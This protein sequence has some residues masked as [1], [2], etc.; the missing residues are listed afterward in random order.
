LDQLLARE[1]GIPVR[2]CED[3]LTAVV[4]GAGQALDQID[5]LHAMLQSS[6]DL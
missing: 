6:R 3:P 4:L 5:K 2:L 1:T